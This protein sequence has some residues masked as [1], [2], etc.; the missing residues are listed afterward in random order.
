MNTHGYRASNPKIDLYV[1][2]AD[3]KSKRYLFSTN[4]SHTCREAATV[5][6]RCTVLA[7]G[8]CIVAYKDKSK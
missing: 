2:S 4:W 6:A 1:R 5:T 7:K 3:G 8:E